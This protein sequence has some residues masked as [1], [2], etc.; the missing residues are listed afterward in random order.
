MTVWR[1]H[2]SSLV[3]R[4]IL[5]NYPELECFRDLAF[6]FKYLL[7]TDRAAF[8]DI[9]PY[10]QKSAELKSVPV[11]CHHTSDERTFLH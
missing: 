3:V 4:L 9:Q 6:Y 2:L 5:K 7:G 1:R 11:T 10:D 8:P